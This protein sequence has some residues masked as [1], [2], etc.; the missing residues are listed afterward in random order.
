MKA[1]PILM[2]ARSVQ[3]ILAG[4]KTQTRR[5]AK[6]AAAT[7]IR[8]AVDGAVEW[9]TGFMGWQSVDVLRPML[10]SLACPYGVPG[11]LLWVRET[12]L[13]WRE[14][15]RFSKVA[16]YAA[17]G[18]ALE[19]AEKWTPSIH[20]PRRASRFTL[21]LTDVRLE[22]VQSISHADIIAEGWPGPRDGMTDEVN[23][24]AA[25]DWWSDMWTDTNGV[26]AW[27]RNDWTWAVTFTVLRENV[28]AVL[29]RR[30]RLTDFAAECNRNAGFA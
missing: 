30:K 4:R 24:D 3:N 23:R 27:N 16:A 15:G 13:E 20:M 1:R 26:G 8:A 2:H 29:A 11:D 14:A 25:L 19:G 5:I 22:R 28:D 17:D 10:K 18:Y 7:G 12:L 6:K 21:E 9:W